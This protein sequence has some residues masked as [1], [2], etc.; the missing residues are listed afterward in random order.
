M[1][2]DAEVPG[3]LLSKPGIVAVLAYVIEDAVLKAFRIIAVELLT[4]N[5]TD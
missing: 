2:N 5:R 4:A 3:W 1:L